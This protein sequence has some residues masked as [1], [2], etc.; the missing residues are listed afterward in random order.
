[1]TLDDSPSICKLLNPP[2]PTDRQ[3]AAKFEG[4]VSTDWNGHGSWIGGNIAAA[5]DGGGINGIAPKVR[6]VAIK[7]AENCGYCLRSA[8]MLD[9]FVW[10]ADNGVDIVSIS[11]GG[12]LDRSNPDA[13][14]LLPGPTST[15]W[16]TPAATAR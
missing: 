12:Y 2:L 1:M 11:F 15:R 13:E 3:L 6:L 7:I 4:P 14:R 10:A 16:R 8:T 9:A 5:L